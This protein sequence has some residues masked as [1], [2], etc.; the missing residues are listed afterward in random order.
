MLHKGRNDKHPAAGNNH[1]N[2]IHYQTHDKFTNY[3]IHFPLSFSAKRQAAQLLTAKK[4]KRVKIKLAHQKY[5]R[6]EMMPLI[7]FS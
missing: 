4:N 5:P 1:A 3:V 6:E 7:S 2:Y